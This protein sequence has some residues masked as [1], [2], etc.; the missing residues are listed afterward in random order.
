MPFRFR[1]ALTA[2]ILIAAPALSA[3]LAHDQDVFPGVIFGSGNANG[4]FTVDRANNIELGL[5]AKVRFDEADDLPKNIFN[6]NGDGTFSHAAGAPASNPTRARWNFE[7]SINSY[8]DGTGQQSPTPLSDYVYRIRIDFDPGLGTNFFDF[9]PINGF[10]FDHALGM[11]STTAANNSQINCGA[12][13]A[14]ADW[15]AAIGTYNVAQNSWNL[16]FFNELAGVGFDP[17]LNGIY[18]F[19][20][21][22]FTRPDSTQT[23]GMMELASTSIRVLVGDATIPAPATLALFGIGLAGLG[24]RLRRRKS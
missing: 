23:A 16:D 17:T 14:G 13:T 21:S 2:A 6:S 10:C 5:R 11:N 15:A 4:G 22:A 24:M 3:P 1:T 7:F 12:A 20:L 8:L 9:D 19:T 18:D